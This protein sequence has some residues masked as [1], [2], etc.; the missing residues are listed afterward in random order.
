MLRSGRAA[1]AAIASALLLSACVSGGDDSKG[2]GSDG[3]LP[4][5]SIAS[6]LTMSGPAA[7]FGEQQK[8]GIDLA[9]EQLRADKV[10]DLE[11]AAAEDTGANNAAALNAYR[12]AIRD[13]PAVVLGPIVGTMVLAMRP[14]AERAQIPLVTT[15]A[16]RS[17]TEDDNTFVFRN[18][19]HSGMTSEANAT[20]ALDELGIKKPAILADNTAFGQG[21]AAALQQVASDRGVQIVANESVDPT[22]ADVTGQVSH[23]VASGADA[24]FVELLTGSP[25]ATAVKALRRAGFEGAI[26]AAPGITSPS[27][28]E[29]LTNDEVNGIYSPGL[30]L[31]ESRPEVKQFTEAFQKK[32]N[33]P[34][35]IYAAV[36]YDT[37]MAVGHAVA[38]GASTPKK[39][40][41]ALRSVDY[42]GVTTHL[43]ADTEGNLAHTVSV[44]VFDG[45]KK[46]SP[47][48]TVDLDF[49][50]AHA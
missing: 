19:P 27:T 6:V 30:V 22:A 3:G 5:A 40:R 24:V 48:Q 36:T 35:D 38:D 41:D 50:K 1:A 31:D 2:S 47:V 28:L 17:I 7:V 15:A 44:L 14:E 21:D 43:A 33:R 39:V 49:E 16:T 20:Y 32:F 4:T 8:A 45:N 18:F 34:A 9:V 23:I 13:E 46:A 12:S 37:V 29:L 42:D 10:A 11:V 25:L 26:F